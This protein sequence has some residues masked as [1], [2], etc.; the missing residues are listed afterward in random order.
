MPEQPK[1][2]PLTLRSYSEALRRELYDAVV[3]ARVVRD[4]ST[5]RL[6]TMGGS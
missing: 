3:A 1:F 2:T 4:R 6:S 5:T